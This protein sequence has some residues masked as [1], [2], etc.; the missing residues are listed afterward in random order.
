MHFKGKTQD[1]K[2]KNVSAGGLSELYPQVSSGQRCFQ[3]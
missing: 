3:A 2:K 1:L